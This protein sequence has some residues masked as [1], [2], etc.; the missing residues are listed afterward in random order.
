M[1]Q[2]L[3][4]V[5]A[6]SD[7]DG[8]LRRGVREVRREELVSWLL[9]RQIQTGRNAGLFQPTET[10]YADRRLPTGERLKTKLATLH[11]MS[12]EAARVLHALGA[13]HP[14]SDGAV[15]RA[16]ARMGETC[17]ALQHCTM[18]ECAASF[19]GYMRFLVAT[20]GEVATPEIV[21]RLRTLAD[22]RDGQGHW[23]RFPTLYTA[24]V[25]TEIPL[26]GARDEL[27]YAARAI[28]GSVRRSGAEP[29]FAARRRRLLEEVEARLAMPAR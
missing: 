25:L 16:A 5:D 26:P 18:G 14:C 2:W 24:L 27:A 6:L 12:H 17:Y 22:H 10:D 4:L 23:K 29:P 9:E 1:G 7:A 3:G 13:G 20:Q 21:W 28:A 15:E 11:I 8:A 19:V